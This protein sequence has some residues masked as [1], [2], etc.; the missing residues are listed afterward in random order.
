MLAASF[1]FV[2]PFISSHFLKFTI[3]LPFT[4][5]SFP[6]PFPSFPSFTCLLVGNV[7]LLHD[8]ADFFSLVHECDSGDGRV[9]GLADR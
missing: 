9:Y 7:G 1:Y 4:S 5:N 6:V 3:F 2:S 8:G